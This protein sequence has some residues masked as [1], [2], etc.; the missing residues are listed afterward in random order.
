MAFEG[1]II[2]S[3]KRAGK[4]AHCT[5]DVRA[6]RKRLACELEQ[7]ETDARCSSWDVHEHNG[8]WENINA[9]IEALI[10]DARDLHNYLYMMSC[11]NFERH[12]NQTALDDLL[13][14]LIQETW[15]RRGKL[16]ALQKSNSRAQEDE[17]DDTGSFSQDYSIDSVTMREVEN[18]EGN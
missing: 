14:V 12:F 9:S 6:G 7:G 3:E 5:P 13:H 18:R 11:D 10:Q 4:Q 2:I 1:A 16:Q 8:S 15:S 17:E